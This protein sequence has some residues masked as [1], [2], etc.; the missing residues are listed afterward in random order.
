MS[1]DYDVVFPWSLT[2]GNVRTPFN[3]RLV[4]LPLAVA[5]PRT[6]AEVVHWVDFVR[7]HELSVSIRSGNNSYEGLS[8]TNQVIIDLTFL[9]LD[10]QDDPDKQFEVDADAGI[11]HVAP[12]MRLGVLYTELGKAGFA[13]AA[14][15]CAPVCAGG[16]VGTGG[17][18]FSTRTGGWA[19]D[20][21][22][23]VQCVLADGSVVVARAD[24]EHA[25]LYR[26]CK[27][28]GG[29]GLCV[30]TRLK[31]ELLKSVPVLF[32]SVV[33]DPTQST[34]H[35]AEVVAAWQNL[36]AKAPPALGGSVI[37]A[38][39]TPKEGS[40]LLNVQGFFRVEDCDVEAGRA[41]L[42]DLLRREWLDH[43]P[44]DAR[45]DLIAIEAMS[46]AEAATTGASSVPM[47][48]YNQWKLKNAFTFRALTA[49]ELE[50]AFEYLRTHAPADDQSKAVGYVSPWLMGGVSNQLDPESAVVPVREGAVMWIHAGAQWTTRRWR[51]RRWPSSP[52]C[53]KSSHRRWGRRHRH[54][55]AAPTS[56][57][58]PSSRRRP[59]SATSTPT[60][61]AR[62][63][64]SCP[65][66]SASRTSTTRATCSS[67][68]R[69]SRARSEGFR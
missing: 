39:A 12:G 58:G 45:P 25:D 6:V 32:W 67:S 15:Q 7:C 66:S 27:G 34:D 61:A 35:G 23:E 55:T 29:A 59:T 10:G 21:L 33:F 11:V 56:T 49:A 1:R 3:Q 54:S 41:A 51:P 42:E 43:L 38:I 48:I 13:L 28:A 5:F 16:I 36:A 2:Y 68:R 52:V 46:T 8:S 62:R 14:G 30:M 17:I 69:A 63:T 19:S 22:L 47:P 44:A 24:N 57:W 26:A 60:G 4:R 65:S 64:T 31:L 37:A 50:P 9:A 40:G 53:G 20:Q 18:G